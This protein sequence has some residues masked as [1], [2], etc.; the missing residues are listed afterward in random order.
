MRQLT[1]WVSKLSI[2]NRPIFCGCWVRPH[3]SSVMQ[4]TEL[5]WRQAA[6]DTNWINA[7]LIHINPGNSEFILFG[8]HIWNDFS[9]AAYLV[10]FVTNYIC[11]AF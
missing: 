2:Q 5:S 9:V 4:E 6:L 8:D 3:S 10:I 11:R 7:S 1:S